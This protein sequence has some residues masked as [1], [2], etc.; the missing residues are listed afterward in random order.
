MTPEDL[1]E[2]EQLLARLQVLLVKFNCIEEPPAPK[3]KKE[4]IEIRLHGH[5]PWRDN[6]ITHTDNLYGSGEIGF[7]T[8]GRKRE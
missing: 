1:E 6:P 4:A 5:H 2:F 3:P 7:S 8:R